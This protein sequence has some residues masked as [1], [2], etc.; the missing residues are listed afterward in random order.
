ML[1]RVNS[2]E[3]I[4]VQEDRFKSLLIDCKLRFRCFP[5]AFNRNSW[6]DPASAFGPAVS[7]F[8]PRKTH[9]C[10]FM[11]LGPPVRLVP[12]CVVLRS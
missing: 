11:R 3:S 6:V 8:D 9:K 5:R 7:C 10:A 1:I 12:P 4:L 2:C